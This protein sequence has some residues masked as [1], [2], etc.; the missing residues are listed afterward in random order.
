MKKK[1]LS[2]AFVLILLTSFIAL[3]ATGAKAQP[4]P[5]M[6]PLRCDKCGST[7][8]QSY[9]YT[10]DTLISQHMEYCDLHHCKETVNLV[11]RIIYAD[12]YCTEC[13]YFKGTTI[14]SNDLIEVW[15]H[16]TPLD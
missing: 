1:L 7:S 2:L 15:P 9:E 16:I 8:Q 4:V 14:V 6:I 5:P 13:G 12:Y 11:R 3:P 10:K